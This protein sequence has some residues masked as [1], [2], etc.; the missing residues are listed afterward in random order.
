MHI[1][2]HYYAVLAATIGKTNETIDVAKD[3]TVSEVLDALAQQHDIIHVM[4]TSLAA[5]V[6]N[7][8]VPPHYTVSEGDTISIIPPVSGG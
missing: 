3:A 2:I 6:D 1:D 5:A 8:Y 4:R 7:A